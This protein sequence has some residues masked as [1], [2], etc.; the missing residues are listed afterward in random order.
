MERER[1]DLA[2]RSLAAALAPFD[3]ALAALD[4]DAAR[5]RPWRDAAHVV[6]GRHRHRGQWRR[7]RGW[8]PPDGPALALLSP[9][10]DA[11]TTAPNGAEPMPRKKKTPQPAAPLVVGADANVNGR[12]VLT[13]PEM[14]ERY[15]A[16]LAEAFNAADAAAGDP[17]KE[18]AA[19]G[20]LRRLFAHVPADAF[21]PFLAPFALDALA[22]LLGSGAGAHAL[23]T[24][25]AEAFADALAQPT[26][27]PLVRAA[28]SHAAACYLV[29]H[30]VTASYGDRLSREHSFNLAANY[31]KRLTAAQT[32]YLRALATVA[33]LRRAENDE[34]ERA[35]RFAAD[36]ATPADR[37]SLYRGLGAPD[38]RAFPPPPP[39]DAGARLPPHAG[40]SVPRADDVEI[41][42]S[43][44]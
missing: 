24:R 29:C 28:V 26:D 23:A 16:L 35:A 15:R 1:A 31:E 9:P 43:A 19:A 17:A 39:G 10:G 34:R 27:G 20:E 44:A 33:A 11:H 21:P 32:R 7:R 13:V 25:D 4:A 30:A 6:T 5:L 2:R 18:R 3:A 22:P 41:V 36:L 38:A 12:T 42:A 40:D 14:P 8:T 37:R